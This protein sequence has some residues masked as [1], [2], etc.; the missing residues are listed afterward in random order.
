MHCSSL[1]WFIAC[2]WIS[3]PTNVNA[4]TPSFS[5]MYEAQVPSFWRLTFLIRTFVALALC[6]PR[7]EKPH[8][9]ICSV[10][11]FCTHLATQASSLVW[12]IKIWFL[13]LESRVFGEGRSSMLTL[14]EDTLSSLSLWTSFVALPP[15]T[16]PCWPAP[17]SEER[18][19]QR[20]VCLCSGAD[21]ISVLKVVC[22]PNP[23]AV[24][25]SWRALLWGFRVAVCVS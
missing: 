5:R 9:T 7:R 21:G 14:F 18:D 6:G 17:R 22:Y 12:R 8:A 24:L 13:F 23:L 15:Q 20:G 25:F 1:S 19:A 3:S 11:L 16:G 4:H 2:L 10:A